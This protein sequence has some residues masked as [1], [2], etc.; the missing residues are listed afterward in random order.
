MISMYPGKTASFKDLKYG[1]TIAVPND[2]TNEARALQLLASLGLIEID[3][4]AGL[5]ATPANITSNPKN[6]EILE[7][8]AAQVPRT[9]PDV[10]LGVVNGNYAI[11]AGINETVLETEANDSEGAQQYANIIAVKAGSENSDKIKAL[12]EALETDDGK[13]FMNEKYGVTVVP[14]F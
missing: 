6:L 10:D 1:V 2:T 3:E 13:A 12:I 8:E 11:A 4:N 14:V 9:L 7:V 5:E